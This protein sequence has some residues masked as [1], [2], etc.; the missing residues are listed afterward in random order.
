MIAAVSYALTLPFLVL[1]CLLPGVVYAVGTVNPHIHPLKRHKEGYNTV[2]DKVYVIRS[3]II[4]AHTKL[5]DL[6][7]L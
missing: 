1:R 2:L 4:I 3:I 7:S 5:P 6:N